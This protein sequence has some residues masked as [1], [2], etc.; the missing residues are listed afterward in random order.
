MA[1]K[2]IRNKRWKE[3]W[4]MIINREAFFDYASGNPFFKIDLKDI[5][6]LGNPSASYF[7][8]NDLVE[9]IRDTK[10]LIKEEKILILLMQHLLSVI[11][12][13]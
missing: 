7:A 10:D 1:F 12:I 2:I 3:G 8:V 4:E 9:M 13:F 5:K 6:C 11:L